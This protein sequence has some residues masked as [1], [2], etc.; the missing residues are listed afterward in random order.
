V[1]LLLDAGADKDAKAYDGKTAL[2]WATGR[3]HADCV[4]LLLDA[5]ADKDA[6]DVYG[7]TALMYVGGRPDCV[8][9]LE[10]K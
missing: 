5:G 9:L 8:R 6:K 4:R 3:C 10:G 2:M 1:R 7:K